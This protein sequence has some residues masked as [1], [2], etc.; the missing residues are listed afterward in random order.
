MEVDH[1]SE[2]VKL[3]RGGSIQYSG[4]VSVQYWSKFSGSTIEK[5]TIA[6]P[7]RYL[8]PNA[9]LHFP[10]HAIRHYRTAAACCCTACHKQRCSHCSMS[11]QLCGITCKEGKS[12]T[13]ECNLCNTSFARGGS[14]T[15][16]IKHLQKH[17]GKEYEDFLQSTSAKKKSEP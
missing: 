11:C 15:N 9:Q 16:L 12:N 8:N 14:T 1:R 7:I 6:H 4:S 2:T 3:S 13:A 5:T 10:R 17:H